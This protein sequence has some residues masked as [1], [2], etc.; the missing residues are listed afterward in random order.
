MRYGIDDAQAVGSNHA[1]P[2]AL[3]DFQHTHLE[4]AP[5]R[6][7]LLEPGADDH[8][9]FDASSATCLGNLR[10]NRR[11]NDDHRQIDRFWN[12]FDRWVCW[13]IQNVRRVGMDREDAT[14]IASVEDVLEDAVSQFRWIG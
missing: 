12:L 5:F 2:V 13:K 6:S 14:G 8:Q 9:P 3:Y 1:H 7:D 4:R 11:R 10:H